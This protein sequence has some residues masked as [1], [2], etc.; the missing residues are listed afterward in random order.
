MG[1]P[2]GHS[3]LRKPLDR[4][5]FGKVLTPSNWGGI[6]KE[7]IYTFFFCNDQRYRTNVPAGMHTMVGYT[8]RG[9]TVYLLTGRYD[10]K[11]VFGEIAF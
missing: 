3:L 2:N 1:N 10:V 7:I 8:A 4:A 5:S 11:M 6:S 9:M